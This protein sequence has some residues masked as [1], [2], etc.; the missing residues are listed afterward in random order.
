[1]HWVTVTECFGH[2]HLITTARGST[3]AL[4]A[5]TIDTLFSFW[6]LL[7]STLSASWDLVCCISSTTAGLLQQQITFYCIL[8]V[9]LHVVAQL[10]FAYFKMSCLH[11]VAVSSSVFSV[12]TLTGQSVAKNVLGPDPKSLHKRRLVY[13]FCL[14]ECPR[15]AAGPNPG[16]D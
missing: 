7:L 3:T 15:L 10:H 8:C 1:V 16:I 13:V 9:L 5:A 14:S 11:I 6:C 12:N 2:R 4:A